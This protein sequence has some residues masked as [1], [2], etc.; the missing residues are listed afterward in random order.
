MLLGASYFADNNIPSDF[1]LDIVERI[2]DIFIDN[3]T[4]KE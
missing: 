4:D 3:N 2:D 1:L